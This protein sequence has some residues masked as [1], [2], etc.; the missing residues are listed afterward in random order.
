MEKDFL[1]DVQNEFLKKL[2]ILF[3]GKTIDQLTMKVLESGLP[4]LQE[5]VY[6]FEGP[7]KVQ[8]NRNPNVTITLDD[9]PEDISLNDTIKSISETTF[10]EHHGQF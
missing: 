6:I 10:K 4:N 9:T 5:I 3:P 2:A 7:E 8:E 1:N